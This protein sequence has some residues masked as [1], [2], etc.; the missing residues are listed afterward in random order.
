MDKIVFPNAKEKEPYSYTIEWDK[1][2][3]SDIGEHYFEGLEAVGLSYDTATRSIQ[4]TPSIPGD[5]SVTLYFRPAASVAGEM[6]TKPVHLFINFDPRSL[7]TEHEPAADEPYQKPHTDHVLDTSGARTMVAA[8]KRGRSHAREAKFR[9]DDFDLLYRADTGWYIMAVA[10]G[11]GSAKYSREGSRIACSTMIEQLTQAAMQE[12][13]Q[14]IEPL[15]AQFENSPD[16]ASR[17]AI[18]DM[19]YSTLGNAVLQAYKNIANE[20]AIKEALVKDYATTLLTTIVRQYGSK[21]FIGAFWVGDGGV[22]IHVKGEV[23]KILG[24]P[25][26][27]EYSGQTRFLTMSEVFEATSLYKRIRFQLV[28]SFDALVLMTDGITDAW[29]HTD[30]NLQKAEKWSELF[31]EMQ[32]EV[33]LTHENEQAHNELLQWL[34]FWV[35][36]EY[37]DRTI[38][39]LF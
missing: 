6:Q 23:P 9:E 10:D 4:G 11:A 27:G 26:T 37:D 33:T 28:D 32:K 15:L 13:L 7:W 1:F 30:A 38:A 36:G 35:K 22:G 8:S 2:A 16:D 18:G 21:W 31:A 25:D 39:I 3:L 19:L 34:D 29:F 5:A 12:K 20:A 24:D 17:K 14:E